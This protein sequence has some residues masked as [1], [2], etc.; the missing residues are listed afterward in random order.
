MVMG[1]KGVI[2][3]TKKSNIKVEVWVVTKSIRTFCFVKPYRD[4]AEV[5]ADKR[6]ASLG[7][8]YINFVYSLMLSNRKGKPVGLR[9][10]GKMLAE[11][12][13]RAG[14]RKYLPSRMTKHTLA[15]AAEAL[16]IYGWLHKFITIEKSVAI[17]EKAEDPIEGLSQLL[18]TIRNRITFF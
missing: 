10:K 2:N 17:M 1:G 6:L 4:L 16:I 7:D 14:L 11:A 5:L 8:S 15:D 3:L 9:V 12:L 18:S 13:K